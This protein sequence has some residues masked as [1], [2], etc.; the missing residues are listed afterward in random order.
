MEAFTSLK[1]D[2]DSFGGNGHGGSNPLLGYNNLVQP[3][4]SQSGNKDYIEAGK[5]ILDLLMRTDLIDENEATQVG[6]II[7]FCEEFGLQKPMRKIY[8]IL[9]ARCSIKMRARLQKLQ[10]DTGIISPQMNGYRGKVIG[11]RQR[12]EEP[13]E[14]KR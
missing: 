6:E 1:A 4:I 7:S 2:K 5:N 8:Y 10:A 13:Y 14:R 3:H 9:A 12:E 11:R